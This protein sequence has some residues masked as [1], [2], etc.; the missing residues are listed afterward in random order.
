MTAHSARIKL[1]TMPDEMPV[2]VLLGS[3]PCAQAA[4]L[5]W[6]IEARNREVSLDKI[7]GALRVMDEMSAWRPKKV[8]D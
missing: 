6:M 8:P 2:F 5:Q 3:D 7:H 1:L 4:V